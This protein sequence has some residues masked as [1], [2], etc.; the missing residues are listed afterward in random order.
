MKI[1]KLQAL[2]SA[3]RRKDHREGGH[4]TLCSEAKA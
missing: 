3:A 4:M 1:N 2:V